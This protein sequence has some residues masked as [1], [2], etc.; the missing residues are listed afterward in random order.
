MQN[1]E[2]ECRINYSY[3]TS[4]IQFRLNASIEFENSDIDCCNEGLT[5]PEWLVIVP[6]D[7]IGNAVE[8]TSRRVFYPPGIS[9]TTN[10]SDDFVANMA[11]LTIVNASEPFEIKH[12]I[13]TN[14]DNRD[15]RQRFIIFHFNYTE[16]EEY[17][18]II[19]T[20]LS[21]TFFLKLTVIRMFIIHLVMVY[22]TKITIAVEYY[23]KFLNLF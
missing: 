21:F 12:L 14:V 10:I 8:V 5:D 18:I 1:Q 20:R 9:I 3:S 19:M 17:C 13:H 15:G 23:M 4:E 11:T 2:E 22:M 6:P 7:D 16:S